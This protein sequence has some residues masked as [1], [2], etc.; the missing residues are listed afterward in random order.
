MV[1][2]NEEKHSWYEIVGSCIFS[3][4]LCCISL[5]VL[6]AATGKPEAHLVTVS[7]E[8]CGYL[9]CSFFSLEFNNLTRICLDIDRI[10]EFCFLEHRA[11]F[12]SVGTILYFR[13][14]FSFHLIKY[15]FSFHFC[16]CSLFSGISVGMM[17]RE[18]LGI[19]DLKGIPVQLSKD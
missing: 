13:K 3:L 19:R 18:N 12:F 5:M 15:L 16:I 4:K 8:L 1:F 2:V 10:I 7:L 11:I 17:C 9:K 14:I 6:R